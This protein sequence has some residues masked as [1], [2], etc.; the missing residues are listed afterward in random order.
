MVGQ[1]VRPLSVPGQ[2]SWVPGARHIAN[3]LRSAREGLSLDPLEELDDRVDELWQVF[4]SGLDGRGVVTVR[5]AAF[6]RWRFAADSEQKPYV[7]CDFDDP[8]GY[9]ALQK[10]GEKQ[11][12]VDL[13]CRPSE[14]KNCLDAIAGHC[15][16]GTTALEIRLCRDHWMTE[17][18]W[19]AGFV[20]RRE[21]RYINV[22]C[23][24]QSEYIEALRDPSRWHFT[25][26]ES[27]MPYID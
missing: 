21:P 19:R 26:L 27:D 3:G 16:E 8:M 15:P 2:L 20:K 9:C 5:D 17:G 23:G 14:G 10:H 11:L 12:V 1:Y 13:V 25:W 22:L 6:Y 24:E 18:L 4:T 7:I